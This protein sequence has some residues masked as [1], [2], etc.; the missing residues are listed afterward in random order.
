[1]RQNLPCLNLGTSWNILVSSF[2]HMDRSKRSKVMFFM[3]REG[4]GFYTAHRCIA[5]KK[6]KRLA[7]R[8]IA[9][10]QAFPNI[11]LV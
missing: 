4:L 9:V 8:E 6:K 10:H 1:M 3:F 2:F 11:K 7:M 5:V